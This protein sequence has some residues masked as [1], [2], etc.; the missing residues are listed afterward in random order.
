M[1]EAL[2]AVVGGTVQ[3]VGFRWYVV[4]HARALGLVGTVANLP[5]GTVRVVAVGERGDLESLVAL[6]RE[7]PPASHVLDV[8]LQWAPA[9]DFYRDFSVF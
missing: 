1:R 6:L 5:D 9:T 2:Q 4:R 7:S 3:G 8:K